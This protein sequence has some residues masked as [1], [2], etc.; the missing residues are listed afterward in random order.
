MSARH[1]RRTP[2]DERRR[3]HSQNLLVDQRVITRGIARLGNLTGAHVVEIG[4]G[5]GALTVPLAQAGARVTAV[6]RDPWMAEELEAA[7]RRCGLHHAV[8]VVR[9]DARRMRW[10]RTPYRVVSN[11]PFGAT[12]A[13]LASMLEDP[14]RGLQRA[15]VL[16]QREV[17]HKR[18]ASPPTTLHS[19]AWAPW[20][21]FEMGEV[22]PR[23]AFRPIPRVDGAWLTIAK[24]IPPVLPE[25]LAPGLRAALRDVWRPPQPPIG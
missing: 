8:R 21:Q 2:R 9:I 24:R 13:L 16:V 4:P 3:S 20:W 10:P 17:A 15:D 25:W 22:V 7:L 19:A 12:T 11:L 14:T 5:R 1:G 23:T 6:E 18:A